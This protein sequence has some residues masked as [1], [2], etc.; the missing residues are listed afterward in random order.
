MTETTGGR[1]SGGRAARQAARAVSNAVRVP[2]IT[3]GLTPLEVLSD[4][5]LSLIEE[6]ADTVLEKVGIEFRETPARCGRRHRRIV[7]A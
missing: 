2:Y 4:E 1:R 5:H 3:R 6:N 7:R